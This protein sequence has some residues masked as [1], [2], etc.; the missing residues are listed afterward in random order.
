MTRQL[1]LIVAGVMLFNAGWAQIS[2]TAEE[3]SALKEICIQYTRPSKEKSLADFRNTTPER[4]QSFIDQAIVSKSNSEETLQTKYLKRPTDDELIFWYVVRELHYNNSEPDSVKRTDDEVIERVLTEKIDDRWLLDNY[5]YRLS[6]SVG[7]LFNTADLSDYNFKLD[8]LG[9]R[10]DTERAIFVFF[11][12]NACGQRLS[13]MRFTGKG[14]P[15]S[16]LKRFPKINGNDYYYYGGFTYPDFQWIGYKKVE[17]YNTVHLGNFY[18]LLLTHLNLLL[19][20]GEKKQ[21]TELY[22]ESILRNPNLF[23]YYARERLLWD[24]YEKWK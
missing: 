16:V 15:W 8:D 13:V 9:F 1:T 14:D 7:M 20:K 18:M 21:A 4:F 11:I 19:D 2:L 24:L 17:S 10:N 6:N 3:K 23:K 5:Y 22:E 12:T